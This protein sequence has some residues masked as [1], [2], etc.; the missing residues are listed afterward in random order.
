MSRLP[1]RRAWCASR[2]PW[3][4]APHASCIRSSSPCA[5]TRHRDSPPMS[6][7]STAR[8]RY[9]ACCLL[10][11]PRILTR[12]RCCRCTEPASIHGLRS[13][14]THRSLAGC[15]SPP[16]T[17]GRMGSIGKIGDASMRTR[18][19]PRA[20]ANTAAC[21]RVGC[22]HRGRCAAMRVSIWLDT[23]WADMERGTWAR[24]TRIVS[25]GLRPALVGSALTAILRARKASCVRCGTRQTAH[26]RR[27][28]C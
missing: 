7:R 9:W 5:R 21:P 8:S 1:R 16:P 27:W 10:W 13:H 25:W 22:R 6:R 2:L 18:R 19:W 4:Q 20:C 11:I 15:T 28:R 26:R 3:T 24:M 12:A 17:V 14:P 23:R